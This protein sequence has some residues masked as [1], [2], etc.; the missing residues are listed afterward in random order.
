MQTPLKLEAF[1]TQLTYLKKEKKN[2][3]LIEK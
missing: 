2:T 3:F 1:K